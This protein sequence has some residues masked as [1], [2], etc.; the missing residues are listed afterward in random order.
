MVYVYLFHLKMPLF[1]LTIMTV[2]VSLMWSVQLFVPLPLSGVTIFL[3]LWFMFSWVLLAQTYVKK[4]LSSENDLHEYL[5]GQNQYKLP[6]NNKNV[7]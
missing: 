2:I 3:N 5:L 7:Y 6:Y 1:I 4:T